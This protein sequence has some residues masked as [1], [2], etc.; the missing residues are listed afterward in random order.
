MSTSTQ[1]HVRPDPNTYEI[2]GNRVISPDRVLGEGGT[3]LLRDMLANL[4]EVRGQLSGDTGALLDWRATKQAN[5]YETEVEGIPVHLRL[6]RALLEVN[7]SQRIVRHERSAAIAEEARFQKAVNR[8]VNQLLAVAMSQKIA[9]RVKQQRQVATN[10]RQNVAV[11][12]FVEQR[13]S[14]AYMLR[15]NAYHNKS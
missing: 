4:S 2:S 10:V 3:K 15:V 11:R 6:N 1:I 5:C 7:T 8:K 13:Q 9:Q 14:N 12:Q